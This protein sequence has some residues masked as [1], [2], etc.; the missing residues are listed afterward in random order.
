MTSPLD[1][2][3]ACLEELIAT[4]AQGGMTKRLCLGGALIVARSLD[5]RGTVAD[6]CRLANVLGMA[7]AYATE[8]GDNNEADLASAELLAVLSDLA[9]EGDED[10]A[11]LINTTMPRP[12]PTSARV[13]QGVGTPTRGRLLEQ[14]RSAPKFPTLPV[15]DRGS[16]A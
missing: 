5:E 8:R 4:S 7:A 6:T 9:D 10:L 13:R 14:R 12:S 16:C 15:A 11:V 3:R 2:D 1:A